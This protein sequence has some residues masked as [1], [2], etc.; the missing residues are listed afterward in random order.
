MV[1]GQ[2]EPRSASPHLN[3]RKQAIYH[4]KAVGRAHNNTLSG[5]VV[6]RSFSSI[7]IFLYCR[8]LLPL[9]NVATP[10]YTTAYWS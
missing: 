4:T 10:N 5:F 2:A 1:F 6:Y 7:I 8:H 3:Q 9:L